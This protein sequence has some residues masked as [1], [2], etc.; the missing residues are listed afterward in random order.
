MV[1]KNNDRSLDFEEIFKLLKQLN[2]DMDKKYVLEFFNVR[3]K[4]NLKYILLK[5]FFKGNIFVI[6][7]FIRIFIN[8]CVYIQ[9]FKKEEIEYYGRKSIKGE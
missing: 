8:V 6:L 9:F 2:V 3:I 1:D 5:F 4:K 7:L